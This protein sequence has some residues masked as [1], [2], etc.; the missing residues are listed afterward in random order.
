ML[1]PLLRVLSLLAL[2]LGIKSAVFDGWGLG[3]NREKNVVGVV[4]ESKVM[5]C[6]SS[7]PM[8]RKTSY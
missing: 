8:A 1:S 7:S 4:L 3:K 5:L 6:G 2:T